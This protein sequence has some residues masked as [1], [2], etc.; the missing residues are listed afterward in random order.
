MFKFGILDFE[1]VQ[2][3]FRISVNVK[4]HSLTH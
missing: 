2:F 3:R 1:E 4:H